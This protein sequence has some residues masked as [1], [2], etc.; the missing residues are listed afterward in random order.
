LTKVPTDENMSIWANERTTHITKKTK[1]FLGGPDDKVVELN[2]DALSSQFGYSC[3]NG[4]YEQF[5]LNIKNDE[6]IIYLLNLATKFEIKFEF[7]TK[8][9]FGKDCENFDEL[10]GNILSL[11]SD[12]LDNLKNYYKILVDKNSLSL[13]VNE[14]FNKIIFSLKNGDYIH[15][16]NFATIKANPETISI[17]INKDQIDN[18]NKEKNDIEIKISNS[19]IKK[20]DEYYF[21]DVDLKIR[22][23]IDIGIKKDGITLNASLKKMGDD[24][25]VKIFQK[26]NFENSLTI[27]INKWLHNMSNITIWE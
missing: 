26:D 22:D 12:E 25:F 2:V 17:Y 1:I 14:N 7:D 23:D 24:I 4:L 16:Y 19:E 10:D 3:S 11:N 8:Y 9:F 20:I 6:D 15:T 13:S 5:L 21:Y 27:A 18:I